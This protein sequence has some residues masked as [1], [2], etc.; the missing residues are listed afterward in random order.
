MISI[1][2]GLAMKWKELIGRQATGDLGLE[3]NED[4]L[5][6]FQIYLCRL[7][8][9]RELSLLVDR[10][11]VIGYAEFTGA[12]LEGLLDES[13]SNSKLESN[14]LRAAMRARV[15]ELEKV[16]TGDIQ[17]SF[18][19]LISF[20]R[21]R[22][23]LTPAETK[24]LIFCMLKSLFAWSGKM[25]DELGTGGEVVGIQALSAALYADVGEVYK[26]LA[27]GSKLT[28]SELVDAGGRSFNVDDLIKPGK[29]LRQLMSLPSKE[30]TGTRIEEVVFSHLCPSAPRATY[31]LGCFAGLTDLQLLLNY[32]NRA[33]HDKQLGSNVL[34][35]GPPGTGKTQLTL[36]L[37]DH[38]GVKLCE[39]PICAKKGDAITG[40]ER[41][42]AAHLAQGLLEGKSRCLLLFDEMEDAFHTS[43]G[44]AKGWFNKLLENNPIP[45]LWISND[46]RSVDPALLRRFDLIIELSERHHT[47]NASV[48]GQLNQLPATPEWI[49]A[50]Q[51][52]PWLTPALAQNIADIGSLLP[53]GRLIR[54]Q[55]KLE[56]ILEKRIRLLHQEPVSV[57]ILKNEPVDNFPAFRVEWLTTFPSLRNVERALQ[58][59]QAA[60]LCLYGPPG[61]GKTAYA[62]ELAARLGRPFEL[63]TGSD[64][65]SCMVGDT[66]QNIAAMFQKAEEAGAVLLLDEADTFLFSRDTARHSWEVSMTNEFMVRMERFSGVFLATTNRFDALDQAVMR[67]FD[68]KVG[69]GFLDTGQLKSLLS[70]LV[71]DPDTLSVVP[72]STFAELDSLT[73]GLVRAAV[74]Q[75]QMMGLRLRLGRVLKA[76]VDEQAMQAGRLHQN[77]IGFM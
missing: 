61:S 4:D 10:Q 15:S 38:L 52:Q 1:S 42:E 65:K 64:L 25:L 40:R 54:N 11:D 3:A 8:N 23:Q 41:L 28:T 2:G 63:V 71:D 47:S 17:L 51:T 74:R 69:F 16:L 58:G 66:E 34:I 55:E 31:D 30:R 12:R 37:A 32:L 68:M 20:L 56:S 36:T 9:V 26:A 45:T 43:R 57:Q 14:Y 5:Q 18:E 60:R 75:L 33:V 73:P 7:Y 27:S 62:S 53:G 13:S 59:N 22:L 49:K 50:L 6:L 44:L 70:A 35:Y 39:V 72:P 19:P 24:I 76:L 46:I 48:E 29:L 67:R 21:D 77:P